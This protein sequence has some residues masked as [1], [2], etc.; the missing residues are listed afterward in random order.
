VTSTTHGT[1]ATYRTGCRCT[2]C[3]AA[4]AGYWRTWR[5]A[6]Q[7]GR[8]RLGARVSAVEAQRL[9]RLLLIEW[10]ALRRAKSA[11]SEALGLQH[12]LPRLTE[13]DQITLRTELRIRQFYRSRMLADPDRR[14]ADPIR[15]F[16]AG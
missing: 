7:T 13:Q 11:L 15:K 1:R 14:R 9:I 6:S 16:F 4:N 3:R 5:T 2:P 8:P 10:R 12:N